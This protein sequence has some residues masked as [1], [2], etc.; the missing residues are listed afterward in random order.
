M[1]LEQFNRA[2]QIRER[3]HRLK[4]MRTSIER[5]GNEA[6]IEEC[7]IPKNSKEVILALCQKE[8]DDLDQEFEN[9]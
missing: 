9:L 7:K 3:I 6:K 2:I 5:N 1:T 4:V 8:I